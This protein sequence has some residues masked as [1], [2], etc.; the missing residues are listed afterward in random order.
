MRTVDRVTA[1]TFPSETL[2]LENAANREQGSEDTA[3]TIAVQCSAVHST[4]GHG[5]AGHGMAWQG[6]AGQGSAG[7]GSAGQW[8]S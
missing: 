4:L 1:R 6:M 3:H 7:Q 8:I 2:L 5:R